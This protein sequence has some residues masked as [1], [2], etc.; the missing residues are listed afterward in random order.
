MNAKV[1]ENPKKIERYI[2]FIARPCRKTVFFRLRSI[3][4]SVTVLSL[5]PSSLF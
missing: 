5:D 2:Y 3:T 1:E 4:S